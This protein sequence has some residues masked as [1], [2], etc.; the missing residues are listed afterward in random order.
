MSIRILADQDIVAVDA[1]FSQLGELHKQPGRSI[2]REDLRTMDAVVVRST[3]RVDADLLE[4]TPVKFVAT[5]T[6]GTDHVDVEYLQRRGI[7]FAHSKGCN[8]NA[9]V[10]Y[11]ITALAELACQGRFDP[12]TATVGIV[13]GGQVG[14]RLARR[15]VQLGLPVVVNDPLLSTEQEAAFAA[16]AVTLV[17]LETALR[18]RVIS[19]H[20]PLTESGRHA[21]R[22]MLDARRLGALAPATV[23]INASRGGVV[24]NL[25]LKNLLQQGQVLHAVL[26]VWE[27]EPTPDPELVQRVSLA[28]PHIAGYSQQAKLAATWLTAAAL[29]EHFSLS[30]LKPDSLG[31]RLADLEGGTVPPTDPWCAAVLRQ[32]LDLPD[33]TRAYKATAN[34]A[35]GSAFDGFRKTLQNRQEFPAFRING[36]SATAAQRDLLRVLGFTLA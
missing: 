23:L 15:L 26:D 25:A 8:A 18:C 24:D 13:G 10:E 35:N 2:C 36:L 27:R 21:T 6:S 33:L 30:L 4:N 31:R 34:T 17:D 29:A 22:H 3:T 32:V 5:A 19:L 14:G 11:C 20:V 12:A 9:V 28:T 16:A 1:A 7:G